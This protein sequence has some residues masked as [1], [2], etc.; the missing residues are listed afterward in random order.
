MCLPASSFQMCTNLQTRDVASILTI[1]FLYLSLK[2][3][4]PHLSSV[5][6]FK[7]LLWLLWVLHRRQQVNEGWNLWWSRSVFTPWKTL[8]SLLHEWTLTL[9][10]GLRRLEIIDGSDVSSYY[11]LKIQTVL[12]TVFPLGGTGT[13]ISPAAYLHFSFSLIN[14]ILHVDLRWLIT[15]WSFTSFFSCRL[16]VFHSLSSI[17]VVKN[18]VM[19]SRRALGRSGAAFRWFQE[20]KSLCSS[21]VCSG[22]CWLLHRSCFLEH[23]LMI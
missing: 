23:L 19:C 16:F 10:F 7:S 1:F 14:V 8:L 13:V 6:C 3:L 11:L 22:T 20:Q 2:H 18:D 9:C 17:C 4:K 21:G 15:V 5:V 12:W